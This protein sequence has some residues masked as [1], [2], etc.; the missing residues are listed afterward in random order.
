[1]SLKE[2]I[3]KPIAKLKG[4]AHIPHFKNTAE[5]ESVVMDAPAIVTIPL[6]Q[7][8]GAECTATVQKDDKVFVGTVIADSTAPLSAPIH[9]SVSGTVKE[10]KKISQPGGIVNAVVIESDGEMTPDPSLKP[11][12]IKTAKQL[13]TACRECG[14]VGL[15]GAG[16]PVHIKLEAFLKPEID[17]LIINCAECEP[18]ITSDYRECMENYDDILNGVYLLRDV[19]QLKNVIIAIEGNKPKAIEKLYEVASDAN[20]VADNVKLMC[21][22]TSYPQGAEKM[23]VYT[24][25]GKKIPLGKLPADVGCA[26]MNITSVAALYR[27]ISTGMPLVTKRITVDGNAIK[28]PQNVIVPIGTSVQDILDFCGG[29]DENTEKI[30]LGGPMMGS[31]IKDT[32]TVIAKQNN[33]VLCFKNIKPVRTTPC[34]RC[35]RCAAACPMLLA[36]GAVEHS[37]DHNFA[38]LENL[39]VTACIECGSCSYVCPAGRPLTAAMRTGK[40]ELRRLQNAK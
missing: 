16:F 33:A 29:A 18:Y 19:F 25:T 32:E 2:S 24:T 12:K 1:M 9:S 4:G 35:G 10:I 17:T 6:K 15:G 7:H 13:I 34:I 5:V 14:L 31:A 23:L 38:N 39:N 26:V 8:I 37:I 40:F 3:L 11:R 36:P 20:D 22:D 28:N 21:L 27:F 30:I